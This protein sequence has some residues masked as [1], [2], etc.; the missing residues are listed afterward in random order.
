M[1]L[2]RRDVSHI[3]KCQIIESDTLLEI[4]FAFLRYSITQRNWYRACTKNWN[5]I[6][7]TYTIL[8]AIVCAKL[9]C[10][11]IQTGK[12][13]R[14]YN[15]ENIIKKHVGIISGSVHSRIVRQEMGCVSFSVRMFPLDSLYQTDPFR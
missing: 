9:R 5:K 13:K 8:K 14:I 12:N 15:S 11:K 1:N 3:M 6:L 4:I 2:R 10:S 7:H